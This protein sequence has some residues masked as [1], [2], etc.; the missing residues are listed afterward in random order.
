MM[1]GF[2]IYFLG[3]FV[4]SLIFLQVRRTATGSSTQELF[5]QDFGFFLVISMLSWIFAMIAVFVGIWVL[6]ERLW[7]KYNKVPTTLV[8]ERK[9]FWEKG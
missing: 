9:W 4:S 8:R 5:E 6:F 3:V 7:G 2:L 1:D